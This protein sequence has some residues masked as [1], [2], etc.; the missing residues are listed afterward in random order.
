VNEAER[1][2]GGGRRE[3]KEKEKEIPKKTKKKPRS[4]RAIRLPIQLDRPQHSL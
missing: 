2:E 3:K 4:D 1:K